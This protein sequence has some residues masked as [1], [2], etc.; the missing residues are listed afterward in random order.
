[1]IILEYCSTGVIEALKRGANAIVYTASEFIEWDENY[2]EALNKSCYV[3][4]RRSEFV[5]TVENYIKNPKLFPLKQD[6]TF[7]KQY[8]TSLSRRK[9]ELKIRY[10]LFSQERS[11]NLIEL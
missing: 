11:L 4:K 1:M 8:A 5:T 6:E 2:I 7:L 9:L 10:H 3:C